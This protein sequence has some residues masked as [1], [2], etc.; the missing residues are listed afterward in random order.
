MSGDPKEDATTR[1]SV[2][3]DVAESV[4]TAIVVVTDVD[5]IVDVAIS[6]VVSVFIVIAVSQ[7]EALST[8]GVR[9][10][11]GISSWSSTLSS[12]D[13]T[14]TQFPPQHMSVDPE[15]DTTSSS[16]LHCDKAV[17]EEVLTTV[18]FPTAGYLCDTMG[19]L[20]DSKKKREDDAQAGPDA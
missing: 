4:C 11:E 2:Q 7:Q 16:S 15:Q 12:P 17:V 6:I 1:T 10:G 19:Y 9:Y 14:S 3:S 8:S 13:T 5:I 20:S 18:A